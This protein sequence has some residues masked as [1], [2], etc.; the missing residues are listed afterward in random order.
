MKYADISGL[1]DRELNVKAKQL[2]NEMFEARMKNALGQLANPMVIRGMRRD[3]ARLKTL[4]TA[5][6]AL[7]PS[8]KHVSSQAKAKPV[9][10]TN[11]KSAAKAAAKKK[12]AVK[13]ADASGVAD[14]KVAKKKTGTKTASKAGV[15][16]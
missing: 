2:R 11:P 6:A 4:Q 12:T 15:K 13:A 1:A 7:A 14:V 8:P 9:A 5:K 3:L 16:G 10:K